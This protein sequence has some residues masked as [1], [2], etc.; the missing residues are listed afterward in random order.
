M[1]K[2]V[3]GLTGYSDEVRQVAEEALEHIRRANVEVR[4]VEAELTNM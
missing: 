4:E 2:N 1:S 3:L